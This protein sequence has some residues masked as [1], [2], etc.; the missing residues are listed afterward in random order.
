MAG[1]RNLKADPPVG[2]L[3]EV[4]HRCPLHCIYCSNPLE[5]TRR[6]QELDT[7]TWLRV[8]DEAA[9]IGILQLHF[10]GG[11]PLLRPDLLEMVEHAGSLGMFTNLIT[12]GVGL[13]QRTLDGLVAA[14]LGSFQLS[15]QA[16]DDAMTEFI[17]DGPFLKKKLETAERVREAG[18][19]LSINSVLHR[20]NMHQAGDMIEMAAQMGAERIELAN[21]QYYG[22]ALL[23][24]DGLMPTREQLEQAEEDVERARRKHSHL[25]VLWV[26]PDY[27]DDFPKPCMGGWGSHLLSITPNG[28]V[29]P[30]LAANV[31]PDLNLPNV[32]E[33]SLDWIWYDS[34]G[35]NAFRGH[36]WM[37][38]PCRSCPMRE[39]DHGGCRCQAFMLTGDATATDPTCIYSPHHDVIVN[40][41]E[42]AAAAPGT[43][44][45]AQA[46]GRLVHRHIDGP[47]AASGD[48]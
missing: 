15:L 30:C 38:E 36:D 40:A 23:N 43:P 46:D 11:E 21:T 13:T 3:L 34:P 16:T 10:S 5:M 8:L 29:Q 32:T 42:Q 19:S 48:D 27:F 35:F 2:L 1:T 28:T 47:P 20:I 24:R 9:E 4:T 39:Q 45:A 18:L 14:D 17:A 22:W 31:I 6:E 37:Q 33:H 41:R 26:I 25:E 12:S 7:A 44:A